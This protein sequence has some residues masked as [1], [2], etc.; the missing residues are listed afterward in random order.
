MVIDSCMYQQT[1]TWLG[2]LQSTVCVCVCFCM[3]PPSLPPSQ[4]VPLI[5]HTW[6][7]NH[8]AIKMS[9]ELDY[10]GDSNPSSS[11]YQLFDQ[12]QTTS[13]LCHSFF[14][15]KMGGLIGLLWDSNEVLSP[16]GALNSSAFLDECR[17][18]CRVMAPPLPAQQDST[19]KG[20]T[21][22]MRKTDSA[23]AGAGGLTAGGLESRCV[24][25]ASCSE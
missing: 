9:L 24:P 8:T 19:P 21:V 23:G 5:P 2:L 12:G 11:M 15:Y 18:A 3:S 25:G 20:S 16:Q 7:Q 6:K 4:W 10:L 14:I 13:L 1:F 17:G 22:S